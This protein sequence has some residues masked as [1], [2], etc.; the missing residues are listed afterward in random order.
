MLTDELMKEDFNYLYPPPNCSSSAPVHPLQPTPS[1]PPPA[2]GA[3]PGFAGPREGTAG[4]VRSTRQGPP[5]APE[6]GQ[7]PPRAGSRAAP[8]NSRQPLP[9]SAGFAF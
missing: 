4:V 1:P 8:S 2:L 9:L 6:S 5:S 3:P 7:G